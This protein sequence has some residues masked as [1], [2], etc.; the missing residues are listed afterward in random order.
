MFSFTNLLIG[1]GLI[2]AGIL[3]VKYTFQIANFT[4]PQDWLERFTGSGST[5]G[6]YKILAVLVALSGLL[7]ATGFG[8]N[9]IS[10][11]LSPLKGLFSGFGG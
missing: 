3:G 5:Y 6:I 1:L 10:L 9:L 8:D 2:S 4:G 11:L 7:T